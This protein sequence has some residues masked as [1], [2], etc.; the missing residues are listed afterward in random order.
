MLVKIF[1]V[2]VLA[3]LVAV[4][5][6]GA[7]TDAQGKRLTD[8]VW[9]DRDGRAHC[10]LCVAG[11]VEPGEVEKDLWKG[12]VVKVGSKVCP[13]GHVIRWTADDVICFNCNGSTICRECKGAGTTTD[14]KVCP[15]C[16]VVV[17][18]ET[19]TQQTVGT[20]VCQECARPATRRWGEPDLAG[21]GTIR[22]GTYGVPTD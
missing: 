19:G 11:P 3:A 2:A 12:S 13:A 10:P 8:A 20:G 22:V 1:G 5:G 7:S 16:L 14:G 4:S 21:N 18:S 6:C 15:E 17:E 9:F